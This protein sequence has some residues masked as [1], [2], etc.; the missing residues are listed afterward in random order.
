MSW[1][2]MIWQTIVGLFSRPNA[3]PVPSPPPSSFGDINAAEDA[4]RKVDRDPI[5]A[6]APRCR[7]HRRWKD[8]PPIRTC[9]LCRLAARKR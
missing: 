4:R 2:S 3:P 5:E 9:L 7:A 8:P 6:P 1:F